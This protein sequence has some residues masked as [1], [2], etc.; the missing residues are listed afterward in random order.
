MRRLATLVLIGV[1]AVATLAVAAAAP[2]SKNPYTQW[3]QWFPKTTD[4]FPIAV[5]LQSPA[6]ATEYKAIGINIYVAQWEGPT[7]EQL[8][9]LKKLDMR[10]I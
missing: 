6:R 1:M 8:A 5:W 3:G 7:E 2:R 4:Y 9:T 10:V